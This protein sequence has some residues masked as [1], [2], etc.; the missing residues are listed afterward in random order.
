M[1]YCKIPDTATAI[2]ETA[3]ALHDLRSKGC[4]RK[5]YSTCLQRFYV[6]NAR[7]FYYKLGLSDYSMEQTE[8]FLSECDKR[9]WLKPS[10]YQGQYNALCRK[11]EE[12]LLPLLKRNAMDYVAFRQVP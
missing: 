11:M 7:L 6:T 1:L 3:A 5:V 4:Y 8:E 12:G 9:G 10:I 2:E